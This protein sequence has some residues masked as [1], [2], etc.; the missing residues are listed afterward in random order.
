MKKT[1]LAS[2]ALICMFTIPNMQAQEDS[3][4][5]QIAEIENSLNY[6][7]GTIELTACNA[8]LQ[9][10]AG[11]RFL[12]AKQSNYVMSD[13][14]GNP[15]DTTILGLLVPADRGVLAPNSWVFTITFDEIGYVK[16]NDAENIDY[17]EL[18]EQMQQ[19]T[20]DD[21]PEREKLGYQP[22]KVVGWASVPYYDKQMKVLHWA[23]ELK[24]GQDSVNTLNYNL[25]VLGK[26]GVFIINAVASMTEMNDVKPN[27]G[28][29][30]SC[31]EF[32]KGSSYFDFNPE[33]DKVAAW[34]IGGLVAGKIL[35][36]VGFLA[37]IAKFGKV[38]ALAFIAAGGAIWKFFGGKKRRDNELGP[39]SDD[40]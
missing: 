39:T 31:I 20:I 3:T 30:L 13:L 23:K 35:A 21:N 5:I 37:I 36:K 25:R 22:I 29:V 33:L 17:D 40:N 38:I 4:A 34:T 12:D 24:F 26:N 15:K 10:P 16:D 32:E 6:Q 8:K 19:E 28:K 27:I 1:T 7:T 11:F 18:L 14:W 9:T 2:I